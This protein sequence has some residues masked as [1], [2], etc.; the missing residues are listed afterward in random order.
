[1]SNCLRF[2]LRDRWGGQWMPFI[3]PLAVLLVSFCDASAT[4]APPTQPTQSQPATPPRSPTPKPKAENAPPVPGDPVSPNPPSSKLTDAPDHLPAEKRGEKPGTPAQGA[5]PKLEQKPAPAE[6]PAKVEAAARPSKGVAL[7]PGLFSAVIDR[8]GIREPERDAYYEVLAHARD[9]DLGLQKA[10]G[11]KNTAEARQKFAA[12]KKNARKKYSLFVDIITDPDRF[13]GQPLTLTGYIHKVDEMAAG[14]NEQGLKTL[15][16]VWMYTADSYSSPYVVV[17][18]EVPSNM[19]APRRGSPTSDVAV[20][21]YFFKLYSY[22]AERGNWGAPLILAR[23]LEW[24][25]PPPPARLTAT[26]KAAIA[27]GLFLLV[28]VI[29]FFMHRRARDDRR[30][31]DTQ[32]AKLAAPETDNL[33]TLQELE[34]DEVTLP[35]K[36]REEDAAKL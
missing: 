25:P 21:G 16:Q 3:A 23:R 7:P 28:L 14:E 29:A 10:A 13:R 35:T 19:P 11:R 33:K 1:M 30:F 32:L 26:Q 8:K 22:E 6:V 34:Q 9:V 31:R 4:D 15:Y 20:T 5:K 18:T 17:C 12:D 2:P 27:T 36:V 24:N